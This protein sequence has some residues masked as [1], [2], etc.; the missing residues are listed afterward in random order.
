MLPTNRF[1]GKHVLLGVTGGIA[2]YKTTELVRHLVKQDAEVRVMMT[3]AAKAFI[4]PL[5]LETLS[6]HPVESEMFPKS[7]FQGTHHIRLADWAEAAIFVP[8][9][10]NFI[11]K[12][13]AGIADDL[14]TTVAAALHCPVVIAPAMNVHLWEN[15]ILQRNIESLKSLG[16]EIC[17]PEEGFL[18]EG[19]H[20]MGR[21]APPE[22][23]VQ[24][25]YRSIHPARNSLA[26]KKVLVTAGPTEEALDPVR[27]LTNKS[28]GKMGFALAQEAFARGAR[29]TLIHGPVELPLPAKVKNISVTSA[30]E[31][32]EAV[33]QNLGDSDIYLSAAAIADYTPEQFSQR[34]IKKQAGNFSLRLK[35]T[36]DI[37]K[38]A[39][40]QKSAGQRIVGFAV[41]TEAGE[42]NAVKKLADKNLDLVVLNNPLEAGAGFRH[43]TNRVT[44]IHQNGK[45]REVPQLPKL[46]VAF[47]IFEFLLQQEK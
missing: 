43:D 45:R 35:R 34:K 44:L 5:T 15:P 24:Y 3:E 2:A 40:A 27:Y 22:H 7:H 47:E 37:L 38:F 33:Q 1:K 36:E 11:G 6:T 4:T 13:N 9:T 25:L 18:A 10:Y 42:S 32:F 17:P 19:Y 8:A 16:Y 39:G 29:V 46:D 31:M 28:S 23:L 21:L 14:L 41:E 26:G 30:A 12:L 20:G